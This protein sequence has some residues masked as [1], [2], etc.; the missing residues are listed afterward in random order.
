MHC[1]G[2]L[3]TL[4]VVVAVGGIVAVGGLYVLPYKRRQ[5]KAD[6]REKID[7]VW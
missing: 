5:L 2:W 7:K 6:M 1:R 4:P 3:T